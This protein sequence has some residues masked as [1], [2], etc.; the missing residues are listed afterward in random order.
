MDAVEL[1][2]YKEY[3]SSRHYVFK[4]MKIN[5]ILAIA[6]SIDLFLIA[7]LVYYIFHVSHA[8][9][10]ISLL[11]LVL[12][13]LF[14]LLFLT[15]VVFLLIKLIVDG[16]F[17]GNF[18][19]MLSQNRYYESPQFILTRREGN[20]GE[21]I[22]KKVLISVVVIGVAGLVSFLFFRLMIL[23]SV[24]LSPALLFLFFFWFI[25]AIII[26]QCVMAVD[27]GSGSDDQFKIERIMQ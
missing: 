15:N 10:A 25:N 22:I 7:P 19:D 14:V 5:F 3:L 26:I 16:R 21:R 9:N 17:R 6:T 2:R 18:F 11:L 27:Y 24:A 8:P 20:T 1:E 13:G 23:A 12:L 4:V